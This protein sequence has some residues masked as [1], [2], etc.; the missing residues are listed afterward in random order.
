MALG[1]PIHFL[2]RQLFRDGRPLRR[3]ATGE[4]RV[5]KSLRGMTKKI[6]NPFE[7]ENHFSNHFTFGF[8]ILVFQRGNPSTGHY[9]PLFPTKSSFYMFL[10]ESLFV[11]SVLKF[12]M[13]SERQQPFEKNT[14]SSKNL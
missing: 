4:A 11:L 6:K 8:K 5:K 2:L 3:R 10:L 12:N 9:D 7:M 14:S 13:G 1:E